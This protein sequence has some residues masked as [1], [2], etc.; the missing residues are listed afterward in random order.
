MQK[1]VP[2]SSVIFRHESLGVK[3]YATHQNMQVL[4]VSWGYG[5]LLCIRVGV[6]VEADRAKTTRLQE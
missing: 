5:P 3:V 4:T 2:W 6:Q 1:R